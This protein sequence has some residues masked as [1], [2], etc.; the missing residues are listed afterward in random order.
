MLAHFFKQMQ[1]GEQRQSQLLM[2]DNHVS[3]LRV[4]DG[5]NGPGERDHS[6]YP[7][8]PLALLSWASAFG[9]QNPESLETHRPKPSV[10]GFKHT[11]DQRCSPMIW[12]NQSTKLL[13]RLSRFPQS[14]T[15]SEERASSQLIAMLSR[16]PNSSLLSLQQPWPRQKTLWRARESHQIP[17]LL[18][19]LRFSS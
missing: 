18:F 11:K 1:W 15:P 4:G 17:F 19:W 5:H 13:A 10:Y 12:A 9:N 2:Y 14:W 7:P 16:T 8:R 6:C 3:T